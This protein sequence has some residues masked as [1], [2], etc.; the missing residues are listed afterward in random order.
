VNTASLPTPA[1]AVA[2]FPVGTRVKSREFD[3]YGT[4]TVCPP[5]D[6]NEG[7]AYGSIM[8]GRFCVWVNVEW[9]DGRI[10]GE[11]PSNLIRP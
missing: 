5:G 1:Q 2:Q 4:V 3:Q 9:D 11:L 6:P 8:G 10:R 7:K